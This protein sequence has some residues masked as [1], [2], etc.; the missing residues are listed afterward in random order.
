MKKV[1]AIILI[2]VMMFYLAACAKQNVQFDISGAEKITVFSGSSG[3]SAE[4]TDAEAIKHI[5]D[6]INALKFNKDKSSSGY[7]GFGYSIKWY[8]ADGTLVEAIT[9]MGASRIDYNGYFYDS[10]EADAEIDTAFLDTL[11]VP[12]E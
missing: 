4:I 11:L 5:T 1:F 6:N 9:V 12:A 7:D 2:I 3:E 8:A 10:M